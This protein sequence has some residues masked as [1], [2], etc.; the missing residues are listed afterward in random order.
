M[1]KK[2][3]AAC[4][5][6]TQGFSFSPKMEFW[7]KYVSK[8]GDSATPCLRTLIYVLSNKLVTRTTMGCR[9]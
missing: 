3:K 5:K 1:V 7:C 6:A 2:N 4:G 8:A 9:N